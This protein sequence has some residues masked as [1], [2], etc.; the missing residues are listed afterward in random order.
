MQ[1]I[2]SAEGEN[3]MVPQTRHPQLSFRAA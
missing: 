2:T 3:D 1:R